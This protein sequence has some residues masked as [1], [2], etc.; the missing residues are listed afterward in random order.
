MHDAYDLA[1]ALEKIVVE[2]VDIETALE[3][4]E[5]IMMQRAGKN[6]ELTAGNQGQF[7]GGDGLDKTV[8]FLKSVFGG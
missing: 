1:Q 8:E 7:F 6:A 4:Y 2:G 3:E 5:E